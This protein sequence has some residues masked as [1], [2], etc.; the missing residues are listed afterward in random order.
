VGPLPDRQVSVKASEADIS[1]ADKEGFNQ[2][3]LVL[4]NVPRTAIF[5]IFAICW[6]GRVVSETIL[7][8]PTLLNVDSA[9]K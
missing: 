5:M 6:N 3:G 2:L 7:S 8:D 4:S 9:S 1:L